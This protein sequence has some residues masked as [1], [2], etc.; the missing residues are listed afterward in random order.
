MLEL[1]MNAKT[2]KLINRYVTRFH[3]SSKVA[4]RHWNRK[5]PKQRAAARLHMLNVLMTAK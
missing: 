2:A 4:K 3:G 5:N 1:R